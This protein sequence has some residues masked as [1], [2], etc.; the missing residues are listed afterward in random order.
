MLQLRCIHRRYCCYRP[1]Y[2]ARISAYRVCATWFGYSDQIIDMGCPGRYKIRRTWNVMN[3]CNGTSI[4]HVQN[5]M[6]TD[7]TAPVI[8]CPN[9]SILQTNFGSCVAS[10]T[11]PSPQATDNCSTVITF[12]YKVDGVIVNAPTTT[13]SLG[14]HSIEVIAN[15][16][17]YNT[18]SCTYNV[19]V[20]DKQGPSITCHDIIVSLNESGIGVVHMILSTSTISITAQVH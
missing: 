11:F 18:S 3:E 4:N 13:L 14:S 15:D 19:T 7:T 9:D 2:M 17:C 16:G 1:A 12:Q 20:E 5:I 8:T 10:Y 6:S